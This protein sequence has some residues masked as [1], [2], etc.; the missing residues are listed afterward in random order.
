MAA[1]GRRERGGGGET[2]LGEDPE[3]VVVGS[4]EEL[5]QLLGVAGVDLPVVDEVLP[6]VLGIVRS[7]L[8]REPPHQPQHRRVSLEPLL[9]PPPAPQ[10]SGVTASDLL[11]KSRRASGYPPLRANTFRSMIEIR[12]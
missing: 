2:D 7:R 6:R 8:R 9:H 10:L 11:E 5:F 4:A 1:G 12:L 3:G